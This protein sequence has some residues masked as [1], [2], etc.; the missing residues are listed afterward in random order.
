MVRL[1]AT[2]LEHNNYSS[3]NVYSVLASSL[4]ILE[5]IARIRQENEVLAKEWIP[6]TALI[7][8]LFNYGS[9]VKIALEVISSF[10]TIYT[11]SHERT[12]ARMRAVYV[13]KKIHRIIYDSLIR[14]GQKI[15][16]AV[17]H[18]LHLM[19]IILMNGF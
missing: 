8:P 2:Y 1:V 13:E 10:N 17:T 7:T 3:S 12:Q 16:S 6:V 15:S 4:F 19:Q 5:S 9:N 14:G 18:Q 11:I